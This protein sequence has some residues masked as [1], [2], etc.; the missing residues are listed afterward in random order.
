MSLVD[1]SQIEVFSDA[2]VLTTIATLKK[3]TS[4]EDTVIFKPFKDTIIQYAQMKQ[5]VWLNN[6][7]HIINID[8]L[9]DTDNGLLTKSIPSLFH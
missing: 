6:D 1:Y 9:S 7:Y 4:A 8:L 2:T 3:G 5:T